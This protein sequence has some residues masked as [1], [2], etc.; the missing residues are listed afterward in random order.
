M[1]PEIEPDKARQL[2]QAVFDTVIEPLVML[3]ADLRVVIASRSFYH[4]FQINRQD[5]E[6]RL[7]LRG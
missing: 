1:L 2:A 4:A 7:D 3:D 6:G 5:T